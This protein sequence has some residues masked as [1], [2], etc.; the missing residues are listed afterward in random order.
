MLSITALILTSFL[1]GC[2]GN[3][4]LPR[5]S[6]APAPAAAV[7]SPTALS[8]S[9]TSPGTASGAQSVTL[10]NPGPESLSAS[11]TLSGPDAADFAQ[12]NTC[13][14]VEAA[15][16]C[17]VSVNFVPSGAGTFTATLAGTARDGAAVPAVTLTGTEPAGAQ[18]AVAPA[19]VDFGA[20]SPGT[21][22]SPQVV[23]LT[24]NGTAALALTGITI[25]GA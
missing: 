19:A 11:F 1:T 8:F 14:Q 4:P 9:D 24:N 13:T 6:A 18:A 2:G 23:T 16:T 12:T 25:T 21:S 7:V 22:A 5:A 20:V 15:A 17:S 3:T 10:T